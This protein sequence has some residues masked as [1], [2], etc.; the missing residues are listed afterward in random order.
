[1]WDDDWSKLFKY[2]SIRET[3]RFRLRRAGLSWHTVHTTHLYL[4]PA[5]L[6]C[7]R[8]SVSWYLWCPT[9]R[10]QMCTGSFH[11]AGRCRGVIRAQQTALE[12]PNV[13]NFYRGNTGLS[14][15]G[16]SSSADCFNESKTSTDRLKITVESYIVFL[17]R[18]YSSMSQ[19][20]KI[21]Q[22]QLC[23]HDAHET[24]DAQTFPSALREDKKHRNKFIFAEVRQNYT[25]RAVRTHALCIKINP[26]SQQDYFSSIKNETVRWA[27]AAVS[28]TRGIPAALLN[29][30]KT[31]VHGGKP[32]VQENKYCDKRNRGIIQ[33]T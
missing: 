27:S 17:S 26:P 23:I 9:V 2:K 24:Q 19:C 32:K 18:R 33:R 4:T 21:K 22:H 5:A 25:L 15:P 1:M 30:N 8:F 6:R 31:V 10:Q 13:K 12:E 7:Y 29:T 20:F 11:T 28:K 16:S 14:P 3:L